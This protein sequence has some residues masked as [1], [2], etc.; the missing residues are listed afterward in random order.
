MAYRY[1]VLLVLAVLFFLTTIM[2]SFGDTFFYQ[3]ARVIDTVLLIPQTVKEKILQR[4][5]PHS[6]QNFFQ[7]SAPW[8]KDLLDLWHKAKGEVFETSEEIKGGIVPHHL[9]SGHT[10]AAFFSALRS[11]DPSTIVLISPSH[12]TNYEKK[13]FTTAYDWKTPYGM[14]RIDRNILRSLSRSGL[15]QVNESV[16]KEEH[17]IYGVV[18]FITKSLPEARVVPLIVESGISRDTLDTLVQKLVEEVPRDTVFVSSVDFS[19][20]QTKAVADFHDF[21]AKNVIKTFDYDRLSNLEIDSQESVYLLLRLMERYGTKRVVHERHTNS[22]EIA[23]TPYSTETT[24]HYSPYFVRG[25]AEFEVKPTVL[26][27]GDIMLNR[28]VEHQIKKHGDTYIFEALAGEEERFFSGVDI[29]TGN[30]EGPFV[31]E[32]VPTN[33]SIAFR[34]DPMLIP[35]LQRYNFSVLGLA[36]NHSLDMGAKGLKESQDHL[37]NAGISYYGRQFGVDETSYTIENVSGVK[38]GFVGF[39]DT[40]APLNEDDAV[41]VIEEVVSQVDYVLVS[42]HWG[43]EYQTLSHPRQRYLAHLFIDA[44]ADVVIGHHPHVVQEMEIYKNRPI[45]YSLGNTVFDQYFSKET[46]EGLA[47]GIVFAKSG[48]CF[49]LI[50]L[51]SQRSR[52]TQMPPKKTEEWLEYFIDRSHV[53]GYDIQSSICNYIPYEGSEV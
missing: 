30:L 17:G 9:V 7:Y 29:I 21:Q 28:G 5:L 22:A 2:V 34:F 43:V 50:P 46:Q 44:G 38:M 37:R 42:V 51:E 14:T 12:F 24:S 19:H 48:L 15:V 27:F 33:K 32:R 47:V 4:V 18:P 20:Y 10:V 39:N 3:N 53:L 36:N 40:N 16:V 26:H 25:E 41:R 45:F 6:T 11:Q 31:T 52:V 13:I 1:F 8:D 23:Y 35:M 49:T